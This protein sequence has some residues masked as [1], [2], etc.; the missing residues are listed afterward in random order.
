MRAISFDQ[1]MGAGSCLRLL[2]HVG[3]CACISEEL[4]GKLSLLAAYSARYVIVRCPT[5]DGTLE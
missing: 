1:V 4:E 5:C 3:L 2:R